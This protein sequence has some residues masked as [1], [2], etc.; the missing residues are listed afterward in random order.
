MNEAYSLLQGW[1]EGSLKIA[2]EI[3]ED[4]FDVPR[5]WNFTAVDL[6]QIVRQTNS[7][8]CVEVV[9]SG[10][11]ASDGGDS[12][13]G[14]G[15][16]SGGG[17]GA[18]LCFTEDAQ[19]E[20]A[21]GTLR[22]IKDVK[23]GDYVATGTGIGRGLVTEALVHPV[24]KEVEVASV[25]TEYGELVGT[26]D[27]PVLEAGEWVEIADIPSSSAEVSM[28]QRYVDVFYNLEVDGDVLDDS[29]SHSYVVNGVVASGLG[30]NE[31]LNAK[32]PRQ[33]VWKDFTAD[34]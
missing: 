10:T 7:R 14:D 17:G 29:S 28:E 2:D 9:D 3:L 13:G 32:F 34:K 25:E 1:A 15:G 30:D 22:S 20:M 21:D 26:P 11:S 8:E 16:G 23:E 12:D 18:L 33:K 24:N 4:Y 31:I 5:P 19:V 6:N 27:H